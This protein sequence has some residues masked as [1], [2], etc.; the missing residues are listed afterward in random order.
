MPRKKT[1][2]RPLHGDEFFESAAV[3]R[4]VV[5]HK[6]SAPIFSQGDPAQRVMPI[7][8]GTGRLSVVPKPGKEAVARMFSEGDFCG[9][10][11]FAGH[12]RRM[13]SATSMTDA[14]I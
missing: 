10:G 1:P 2:L 6:A 9:E 8:R 7:R 11:C 4:E 5:E 14:T 12:P 3:T 13:A